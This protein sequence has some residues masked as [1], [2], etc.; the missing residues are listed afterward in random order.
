MQWYV[1]SHTN[2]LEPIK[3][4]WLA[5]SLNFTPNRALIPFYIMPS[6]LAYFA[7][8]PILTN[9]KTPFLNWLKE[10]SSLPWKTVWLCFILGFSMFKM[11]IWPMSTFPKAIRHCQGTSKTFWV[12]FLMVFSLFCQL[13]LLRALKFVCMFY[14]FSN[15][16]NDLSPPSLT[17]SS[18][19]TLSYV[20]VICALG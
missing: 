5:Q 1:L 16:C 13:R 10:W 8:W 3:P 2:M 11:T 7:M 20:F 6:S 18:D 4:V 15:Y 9:Q 19:A 12:F 17:V 14:W